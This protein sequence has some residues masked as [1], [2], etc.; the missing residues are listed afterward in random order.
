MNNLSTRLCVMILMGFCSAMWTS[1]IW[2]TAK[3]NV[4]INQHTIVFAY[5]FEI[6]LH[7]VAWNNRFAEN[8]GDRPLAGCRIEC[9]TFVPPSYSFMLGTV[10]KFQCA[11]QS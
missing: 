1:M 9:C 7:C 4:Y 3:Q 10:H 5:N 11:S 6:L 8:C 2:I